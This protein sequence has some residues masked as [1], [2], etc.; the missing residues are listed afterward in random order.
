LESAA[1]HPGGFFVGWTPGRVALPGADSLAWRL[2]P[3]TDLVLQ[4]HV[5]GHGASHT[6][7]PQVA[8]HFADAPPAR[9]PVVIMLGSRDIDI[10]P[11]R[12][13]VVALDSVELPVDVLVLGLYPHAHYLGRE[14]HGLATLPNGRVRWLIR[15]PDWDFNW[16]DEYR[17][18]EPLFLPRGS[19]LTMR[20]RYDNTSRNPRNPNRPPQRVVYGPRSHDEMGDLVIQVLPRT[21]EE[22][23]VLARE[24]RWKYLADQADWLARRAHRAGV[25]LARAGRHREAVDR[26]REAL[27]QRPTPEV[28]AAIAE[29]QILLHQL[30]AARLH[31]TEA[32]RLAEASGNRALA[33]ELRRRLEQL[34]K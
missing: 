4:V 17:L 6:I 27:A 14:L 1:M 16:Q 28:H 32:A 18:A 2:D 29:Q 20:W 31:L 15:V 12:S 30:D 11:D 21:R 25:E 5:P 33:A 22:G 34:R 23:E 26:F 3:A 19:R 8:L 13:D 9:S 24:M 10:P 7:T